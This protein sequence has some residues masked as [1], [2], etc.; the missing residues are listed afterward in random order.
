MTASFNGNPR[1]SDEH[2]SYLL[3]E[4]YNTS[5]RYS[6]DGYLSK[7]AL[8]LGWLLCKHAFEHW[9]LSRLYILR[10]ILRSRLS[11]SFVSVPAVRAILPH[12]PAVS[13]RVLLAIDLDTYMLHDAGHPH[14]GIL[15]WFSIFGLCYYQLSNY[16]RS[17]YCCLF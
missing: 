9:Q 7:R 3:V 13:E 2:R 6:K 1:G 11:T 17:Y 8:K 16:L 4:H 5:Y 14:A 15:G 12:P 10:R